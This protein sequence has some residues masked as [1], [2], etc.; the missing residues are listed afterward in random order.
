MEIKAVLRKPYEEIDKLEFIVNNNHEKGYEIKET[1]A[2]LQAWGADDNDLFLA[3]KEQ[4]IAE[5]DEK[6]DTAL[7]GGVTY[8]NV[9]FDSDTDQKT[10]L[11]GEIMTMSDTDTVVWFGMDN[12]GLLCTKAD[13]MAIG[14]LITELHSFCWQN[15]AY[16]KEQIENA[17]SIEDL[18]MININYEEF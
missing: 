14:G 13:L 6:R 11:I 7:L 9:L 2:E 5:N 12:Q 16:I 4:R 8:N 1:D 3:R 10:N 17:N 15:N 18:E